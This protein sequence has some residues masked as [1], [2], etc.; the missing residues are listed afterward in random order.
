MKRI[1]KVQEL[2]KQKEDFFLYFILTFT[3]S[4]NFIFSNILILFSLQAKS[5]ET[6]NI[7]KLP[8][9]MSEVNC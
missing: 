9:I 7:V 5:V 4:H 1:L 2:L 8:A 3:G 6:I